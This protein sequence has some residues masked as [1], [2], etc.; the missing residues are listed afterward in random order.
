MKERIKKEFGKGE[1][2]GGKKL[3]TACA[4]LLNEEKKKGKK[5]C[6]FVSNGVLRK[7]ID[8]ESKKSG[9]S[10][11]SISLDTIQS[12]IKR[13]NLDA[14]NAP[15]H[16]VEPTICQFCIRLGKMGSPLTKTTIIELANDLLADTLFCARAS[17][18]PLDS[19]S[20]KLTTSSTF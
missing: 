11:I 3:I 20:S 18:H 2:R 7:I 12:R 16:N 13:G 8:E 14:Y 4:T 6:T 19:I 1:Q 9:L 15:I 17:L 10:N 5:A